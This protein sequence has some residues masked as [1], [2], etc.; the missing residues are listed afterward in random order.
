[1]KIEVDLKSA[2]KHAYC[3]YEAVFG[4]RKSSINPPPPPPPPPTRILGRGLIETAGL[5]NLAQMMVCKLE[6]KLGK[7]KYKKLQI[8]QLM[9]KN[10]CQL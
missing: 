7:L 9:I 8:M 10:K 4:C 3:F 6:Y 1:M 2:S 5:F